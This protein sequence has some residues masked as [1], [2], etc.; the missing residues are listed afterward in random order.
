[1]R[2]ALTIIK[3]L[4]NSRQAGQRRRRAAAVRRIRFRQ[5]RAR[6]A[7]EPESLSRRILSKAFDLSS[8]EFVE[9]IVRTLPSQP[10]AEIEWRFHFM[11]GAMFYTMANS[12]RI[13]ALTAGRIESANVERALHHMIPFL[14]AGFRSAPAPHSE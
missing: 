2:P 3:R 14:A 12:C 9:A 11:P 5:L 6:L 13:Q 4:F 8:R 7:A 10:R 1:M